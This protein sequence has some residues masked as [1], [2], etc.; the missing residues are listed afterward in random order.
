[1][2]SKKNGGEK[3]WNIACFRNVHTL[4]GRVRSLWKRGKSKLADY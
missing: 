3:G 1:M 2:K 4:N